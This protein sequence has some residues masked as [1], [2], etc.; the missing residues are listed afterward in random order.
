M[1]GLE[2]TSQVWSSDGDSLGLTDTGSS[3]AVE[4]LP[5]DEELFTPGD[6]LVPTESIN[7]SLLVTPA[8]ELAQSPLPNPF[9]ELESPSVKP[10]GTTDSAQLTVED[11]LKSLPPRRNSPLEEFLSLKPTEGPHIDA[12]EDGRT[13]ETQAVAN[14]VEAPDVE[15]EDEHALAPILAHIDAALEAVALPHEPEIVTEVEWGAFGDGAGARVDASGESEQIGGLVGAQTKADTGETSL[16]DDDVRNADANA[17]VQTAPLL[18]SAGPPLD[19]SLVDDTAHK[20]PDDPDSTIIQADPASQSQVLDF[21]LLDDTAHKPPDESNFT[22]PISQPQTDNAFD[23]PSPDPQ[24]KDEPPASSPSQQSPPPSQSAFTAFL[25]PP[26]APSSTLTSSQTSLLGSTPFLPPPPAAGPLSTGFN[27]DDDGFGSDDGFG[28]FGEFGR[29]HHHAAPPVVAAPVLSAPPPTAADGEDDFGD[30]DDFAQ[31]SGGGVVAA[32]D[33]RPTPTTAAQ[34][35]DAGIGNVFDVPPDPQAE[36]R[37]ARLLDAH[38]PH[39]ALSI[40]TLVDDFNAKLAKLFPAS[41][42]PESS[43]AGAVVSFLATDESAADDGAGATAGEGKP[44]TVVPNAGFAGEEWYKT[45]Q[46]LA[47]ETCYNDNIGKQFRWRKSHIRHAFLQ[48]LDI[49]VNLDDTPRTT[50]P[51][52]L[53]E[54]SSSSSAF[55]SNFPQQGSTPTSAFPPAS[56]L[57]TPALSR[58]PSDVGSAAEFSVA[59]GKGREQ[60]LSEAKRLCDLTEDDLRNKS[61][62]ELSQLIAQLTTYHRKLQDQANYW[63][64]S[65]EQLVMDAEMHNKMIA[66]LVQYAQMQQV[67]PKAGSRSTSPG[68]K[69][70]R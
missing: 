14:D 3:T 46:K 61:L 68:K 66:S 10:E 67:A 69:G 40:Q 29:G 62:T 26:P 25:P 39:A 23:A 16:L 48:G 65:K 50:A 64:D 2:N 37:I 59:K 17:D 33:V 63:L 55:F 56:A 58:Q 21:S 1:S 18:D 28:D 12:G 51:P 34:N 52:L 7:S 45:Y 38:L 53:H 9:A 60:E 24:P 8:A 22:T 43:E 57:T 47:S 31:P 35:R 15:E 5:P 36:E 32:P 11:T 44:K 4:G 54:T 41:A 70:R 30:F 27:D 19:F 42:L 49:H 13:T 20:P 6:T